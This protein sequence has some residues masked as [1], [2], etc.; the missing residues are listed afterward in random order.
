MV[1]HKEIGENGGKG[2]YIVSFVIN[3]RFY[4]YCY[5]YYYYFIYYHPVTN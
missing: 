1:T 3:K 2:D 4:Y 5:Y